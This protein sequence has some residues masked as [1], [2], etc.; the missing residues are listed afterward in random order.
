MSTTPVSAM[1]ALRAVSRLASRVVSSG[2]GSEG[3]TEAAGVGCGSAFWE[4]LGL[5]RPVMVAMV[6]GYS[7]VSG[8]HVRGQRLLYGD[9]EMSMHL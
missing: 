2:V 3:G 8:S 4:L 6:V 1:S 7:A 9:I 5:Q